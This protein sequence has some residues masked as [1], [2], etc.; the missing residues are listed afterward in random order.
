MACLDHEV[1]EPTLHAAVDRRVESF[2]AHAA[3]ELRGLGHA[4]LEVVEHKL[5]R[6]IAAISTPARPIVR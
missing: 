3:C 6:G 2:V 1:A 4:M 5:R